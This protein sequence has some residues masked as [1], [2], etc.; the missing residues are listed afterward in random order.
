MKEQKNKDVKACDAKNIAAVQ[1]K[2][3]GDAT[4]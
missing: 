2:M 1:A 4:P 3:N